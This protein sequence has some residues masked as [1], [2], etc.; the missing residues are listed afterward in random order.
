MSLDKED[1]D[2]LNQLTQNYEVRLIETYSSYP[3]PYM[4]A[5]ELE[6]LQRGSF[7]LYDSLKEKAIFNSPLEWLL[8][9]NPLLFKIA[10]EEVY[11][12][13][14]ILKRLMKKEKK[15]EQLFQQNIFV[16]NEELSDLINKGWD[17]RR[18]IIDISQELLKLE[19]DKSQTI[20]EFETNKNELIKKFERDYSWM[21]DSDEI[22]KYNK[23]LSRLYELFSKMHNF[24]IKN[25]IYLDIDSRF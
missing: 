2:K 3:K 9:Y 22:N 25:N 10:S 7:I 15:L 21:Q 24:A 23:L 20:N 19:I 8:V 6:G 11:T 13:F 14:S 16:M 4:E 18:K 12:D 17:D 5:I 1:Q